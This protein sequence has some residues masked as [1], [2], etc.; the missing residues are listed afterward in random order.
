LPWFYDAIATATSTSAPS[1]S[2]V[3]DLLLDFNQ[4]DPNDQNDNASYPILS[5]DIVY[6]KQ[7]EAIFVDPLENDEYLPPGE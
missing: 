4:P 6:T 3:D 1:K 2:L 5:D 7:N